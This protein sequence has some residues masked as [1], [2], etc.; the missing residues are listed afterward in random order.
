GPI[1]VAAGFD[2][3]GV[4]VRGLAALGFHFVE[5]GTVTPRPQPGNPRPRLFRLPAEEALVN[6]LGFNN[7]G[8]GALRRRLEALDSPDG[9]GLSIPVGVNIGKNRDTPLERAAD[10]YVACLRILSPVGD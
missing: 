7:E 5:A 1:G 3:D 2:K 6:R 8:A 4:A 10:D 9:A